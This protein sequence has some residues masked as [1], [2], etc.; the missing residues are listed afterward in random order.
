MSITR[1]LSRFGALLRRGRTWHRTAMASA[2]L[3][4]VTLL[5]VGCGGG[6]VYVKHIHHAPG[7][8]ATQQAQTHGT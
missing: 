1:N 2:T 8:S 7:R 5:S 6:N 3:A 4:A